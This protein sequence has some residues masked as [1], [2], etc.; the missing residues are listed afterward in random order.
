MTCN[1][2]EGGCGTLVVAAVR[3]G[4]FWR[5]GYVEI[6]A[7]S[8]GLY[9]QNVCRALRFSWVDKWR[10]DTLYEGDVATTGPQAWP[11]DVTAFDNT[12]RRL[13]PC[14]CQ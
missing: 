13:S 4:R 14:I 3:R 10:F 11:A 8:R 12:R 1:Q 5:C 9:A 7:E 6:V 2:T